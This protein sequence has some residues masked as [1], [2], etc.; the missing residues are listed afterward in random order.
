[1]DWSETAVRVLSNSLA[2]E[3]SYFHPL[4]H[5]SPNPLCTESMCSFYSEFDMS[6]RSVV[7]Y[8]W[9][10]NRLVGALFHLLHLNI[11]HITAWY[12]FS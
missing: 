6:R 10:C 8:K 1:M 11:V 7:T 3:L 12:D 4:K 9:K 2:L 5:V